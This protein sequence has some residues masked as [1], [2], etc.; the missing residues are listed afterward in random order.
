MVS[1][2]TLYHKPLFILYHYY[3][4]ARNDNLWTTSL[5]V[6]LRKEGVKAANVHLQ[7]VFQGLRRH[8]QE[9]GNLLRVIQVSVASL[10]VLDQVSFP[11]VNGDPE[12][13][14]SGSWLHQDPSKKP[15]VAPWVV[16]LV[17]VAQ[18]AP[19]VQATFLPCVEHHGVGHIACQRHQ[20]HVQMAVQSP[21]FWNRI[22]SELDI[23]IRVKLE[24]CSPT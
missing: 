14:Q 5:P 13:I 22:F 15:H 23:R 2:R 16:G 11:F 6:R 9:D 19:C 20:S 17:H 24:L 21:S 1:N 10:H 8:A 7:V 4:I 12:T 3:N 18:P